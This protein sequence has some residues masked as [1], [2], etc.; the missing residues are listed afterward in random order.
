MV[1]VFEEGELAEE[2]KALDTA[3]G[4]KLGKIVGRGDFPG[5]TG[6]T[7]LIGDLDGVNA[8]RVL[9]VGLGSQKNYNR[10]IFRKALGAAVTALNR[11]RIAERG[12]R[13]GASVVQ[14]ARR[15]LLRPGDRGSSR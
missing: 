15:L 4:G 2:A 1:G 6:E 8:T 11:T 9:L 13:G 14:R 10:K 12:V 3:A 5:K 7:L